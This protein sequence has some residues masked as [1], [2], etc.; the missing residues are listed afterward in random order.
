MVAQRL[1]NHGR[2]ARMALLEKQIGNAAKLLGEQTTNVN[3]LT[4]TVST[5]EKDLKNS[6]IAH[7]NSLIA[8]QQ[9]ET[10]RIEQ[11]AIKGRAK[12]MQLT[13]KK[14]LST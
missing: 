9:R 8:F 3:D 2:E 4:I 6:V 12:P 5:L 11:D 7:N 10:A 1:R 14:K 13:G